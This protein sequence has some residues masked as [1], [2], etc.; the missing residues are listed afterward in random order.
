MDLEYAKTLLRGCVRSELQDHAFGDAEVSWD[1]NGTPL[2]DGYFSATIQ[3]VT[4]RVPDDVS[5]FKGEEALELRKLGEEGAIGRNDETGPDEYAEGQ[6]M[7]S[8]T[9]N[10]VFEELTGE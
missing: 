2:A 3:S 4:V 1:Y 5:V 8:L 6:I 10:A 7:P 9:K